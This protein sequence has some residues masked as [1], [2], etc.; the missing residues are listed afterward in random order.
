LQAVLGVD[1]DTFTRDWHTATAQRTRRSSKT[2]RLA[3]AFG[4]VLIS[5]DGSGGSICHAMR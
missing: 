1:E 3:D 4:R 2:T 5:E